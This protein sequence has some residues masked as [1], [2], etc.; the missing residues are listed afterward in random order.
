M[1]HIAGI[2]TK[3]T[4]VQTHARSNASSPGGHGKAQKPQGGTG[5]MEL[6]K[7]EPQEW[8]EGPGGLMSLGAMLSMA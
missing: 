3:R 2:D 5:G 1:M 4:Q 7:L 8:V 6:I